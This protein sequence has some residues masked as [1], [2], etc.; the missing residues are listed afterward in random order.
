MNR[1][2]YIQ[3]GNFKWRTGA[4]TDKGKQL[5]NR[6][7]VAYFIFVDDERCEAAS[8]Q[9]YR[10]AKLRDSAIVVRVTNVTI[11]FME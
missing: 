4:I 2:K 3:N 8:Y 1:A 5:K 9:T 11:A 10:E 6:K 7:T